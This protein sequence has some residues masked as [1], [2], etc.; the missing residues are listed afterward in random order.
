MARRSTTARRSTPTRRSGA[1]C[2]SRARDDASMLA[3]LFWHEPRPEVDVERY[4]A[5][6]KAFHRALADAPPPSF[7]ASFSLRLDAAPWE[8]GP[9]FED[10]YLVEDWPAL[11]TLNEAAVR[12][13]RE[14]AHDA[15][16]SL[17]TN[18]A[19]GLYL[20]QHGT[21]DGPAPWAGWVVKPQ[22]EPH[23]TFEPQLRAAVDAAGGGG[24]PR[25]PT[26]VRPG[27][28]GARPPRRAPPPPAPPPAAPPP[29][30]APRPT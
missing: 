2:R 10:W 18:G 20:L 21:L 29:A 14:D 13:P 4:V 22:G 5:R 9:R 17:A 28:G 1:G 30:P 25:P 6:L 12:A 16:A 24:G 8:G 27:P 7:V 23:E 11:G 19:G 3:Y 26:G 15:I